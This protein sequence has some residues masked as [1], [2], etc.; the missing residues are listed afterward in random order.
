MY[1]VRELDNANGNI[2]KNAFIITVRGNEILQ[3]DGELVAVKFKG[4]EMFVAEEHHRGKVITRHLMNFFNI[5]KETTFY[6]S[7]FHDDIKM[8]DN[9]RFNKLLEEL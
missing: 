3:S 9:N 5:V 1:N 2:V 8:V 7:V 6:R 4:G